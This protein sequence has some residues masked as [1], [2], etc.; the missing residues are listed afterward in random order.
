MIKKLQQL[1]SPSRRRRSSRWQ[2]NRPLLEKQRE[3]V[4]LLMHQQLGGMR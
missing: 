3:D 2:F 1:L 4:F